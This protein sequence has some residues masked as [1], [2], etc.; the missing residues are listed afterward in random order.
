MTEIKNVES[1]IDYD[2]YVFCFNC[3]PLLFMVSYFEPFDL[4]S[5]PLIWF[6][7]SVLVLSS[8]FDFKLF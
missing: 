2:S 4:F 1:E 8:L 3:R 7:C 6:V 5:D